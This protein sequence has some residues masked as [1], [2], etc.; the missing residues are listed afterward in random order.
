MKTKPR[1]VIVTP[2]LAAANNGNWQTARRWQAMLAADYQVQLTDAW[3]PGAGA[4]LMIALHARRSAP[5]MQA[6]RTAHPTR[7]LVLVL[8]GTDLY[9][10]IHSD[11]QAQASLALA[12]KLVVLN[13][14]GA[15][16]L[17]PEHRAKTAVILQSSPGRRT[18]P[19]T[20]RHLRALMVG[21]LRDEKS[22]R[23]YFEAARRLA[24]RADILLDHIG[25]GLDPALAAEATAL[26]ASQPHYRWLGALPH[27]ATRAR[28]QAAHVLVHCSQMEGGAH[29][30]IE[31]L[32]SGTPV[33]ASRIDGNL[34]LL[35]SDHPG[36]FDWGDAEALA[37]LLLQTRD[38]VAMLP[39]LQA[40]CARR[41]PLFHPDHERQ[42][43]RRLLAPLLPPTPFHPEQ[44]P[45]HERP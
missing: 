4:Q 29:V 40:A 24:G 32:T 13:E 39:S 14:L 23:T 10:D 19:K 17:P 45:S 9:R 21:H 38:N 3:A 33:L 2:A 7:P 42:T 12:D 18:L 20:G 25:G 37:G 1:I 5:A 34:G 31:A 6:W 16:Q 22:P 8:T 44:G 35:G 11:A 36:L 28:I 41:A 30:V 26:A 43:L 15:R 27:A